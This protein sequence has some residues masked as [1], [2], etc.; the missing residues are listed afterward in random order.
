MRPVSS[1]HSLLEMPVFEISGRHILVTGG[2]SGL[3]RHF[4]RFL[5]NNGAR[6]TLM[7]RRAEALAANVAEI[8]GSGGIAQSV[9]LDV[10]VADRVDG[11]LQEAEAKFGPIQAVVNNA[12]VTATKPA[13]D[14]DERAWDSV[15]D[16]NQIGRAHV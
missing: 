16:T 6:I 7:A 1:D 8:N 9:V 3:G 13:L 15:I 11:A 10:T 2:S 14:Q 4:A 12:G 5:A